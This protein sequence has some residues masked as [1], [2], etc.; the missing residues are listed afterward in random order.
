[1]YT[2]SAGADLGVEKMATAAVL[3]RD[4][5]KTRVE[6]KRSARIML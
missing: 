3:G 6:A 4:G 2:S 1:M 5:K